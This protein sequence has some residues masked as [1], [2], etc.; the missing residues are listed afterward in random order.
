MLDFRN[1]NSSFH[2]LVDNWLFSNS[3]VEW[4]LTMK[5]WISYANSLHRH[6]I[7][8]IGRLSDKPHITVERTVREP[9]G[10]WR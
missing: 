4:R 10:L 3:S 2:G 5:E 8:C 9:S 6:A 7:L 1:V